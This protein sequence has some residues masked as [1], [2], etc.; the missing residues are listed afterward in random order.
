MPADLGTS[1]YFIKPLEKAKDQLLCARNQVR[2]F[3]FSG[4]QKV[5]K[6]ATWV[7]IISLIFHKND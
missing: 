6:N 7:L 4:S 5:E 3:D 1:F 2:W